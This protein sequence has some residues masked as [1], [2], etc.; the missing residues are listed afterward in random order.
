M[1]MLFVRDFA[2]FSGGHLKFSDYI[3]HTAASG[4]A[5]PVLYQTRRS[6]S[7][8]GN[9][10]N[11]YTGA[12]IDELRPFPAYFIAG[13]DW[14]ILDEAKIDPDGSPVVNF[15]QHVRHAIP[16]TPLFQCLAR[17]ALRICVSPAV[18]D[19][20]RGHANGEIFVIQNAVDVG[21]VP[22]IR[23]IGGPPRVIVAGLKNAAIACEVATR[24]APFAEV[25]LITGQLP[26]DVFLARVA[27]ASICVVLPSATEGFF[28]PPLEAMALGRGVITPDCVGNLCYCVADHNCLMPKY[29]AEALA[30]AALTLIRDGARLAALA[31]EGVKTASERSLADERKEYHA[32]LVRYLGSS[33]NAQRG[34]LLDG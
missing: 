19:A 32:I 4:L 9:I 20:I 13:L 33:E 7:V 15:I 29:N 28:L 24:L 21:S 3:K 17:P 31:A 12:T 30:D 16:H 1:E 10:F 2:E 23:S 25:D 14:F 8:A 6:R 18:A 11:N 26:R 5:S 27:E 22:N 34:N